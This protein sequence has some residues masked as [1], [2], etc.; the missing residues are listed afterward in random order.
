[1]KD[2]LRYVG[3]KTGNFFDVQTKRKILEAVIKIDITYSNDKI[4]N[5]GTSKVTIFLKIYHKINQIQL[6]SNN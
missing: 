5:R 1:M 3:I 2:I 4:D 6:S